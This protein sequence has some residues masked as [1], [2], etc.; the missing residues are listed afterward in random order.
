MLKTR[1]T[2]DGT[3]KITF[4]LPAD[5]PPTSVVGDF[6]GWD[7]YATPMR[8]RSNGTRSAVVEVPAGTRLQFRYL[9]DG[10][11]WHNDPDAEHVDGHYVDAPDGLL[12]V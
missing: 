6:N 7:P 3:V 8:K 11:E 2:R 10:G 4:S 1:P 9:V 5:T 12:T